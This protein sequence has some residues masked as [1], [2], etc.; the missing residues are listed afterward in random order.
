MCSSVL[1]WVN[2]WSCNHLSSGC[3]VTAG[4]W[5]LFLWKN[6]QCISP[7]LQVYLFKPIFVICKMG[8]LLTFHSCFFLLFCFV[9]LPCV[10][11]LVWVMVEL[12]CYFKCKY[13]SLTFHSPILQ[14][15]Q[16]ILQPH[17]PESK[18]LSLY[19]LR[20]VTL[21]HTLFQTCVSTVSPRTGPSLSQG[22]WGLS[23]G[24]GTGPRSEMS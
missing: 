7:V 13:L 1:F 23:W 5:T 21:G 20:I 9:F 6:S 24:L 15:F 19:E 22:G 14:L 12:Q 2:L 3:Q 10:V 8:T 16:S 11:L 4:N 18:K 17:M